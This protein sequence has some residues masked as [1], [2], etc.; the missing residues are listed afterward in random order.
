MKSNNVV[1]LTG[2][3]TRDPE[4]KSVGTDNQVAKFSLA[5]NRRV[6]VGDNWGR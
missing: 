5:V 1:M 6:K 4:V 2:N 3:L